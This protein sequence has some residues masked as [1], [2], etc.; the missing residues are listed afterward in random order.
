VFFI[1]CNQTKKQK[2]ASS[3]TVSK[4]TIIDTLP[5]NLQSID[6]ENEEQNICFDTLKIV[7]G[8]RNL[9]YY[10]FGIH[11]NIEEFLGSLPKEIVATKQT[12]MNGRETYLIQIKNNYIEV[13][14]GEDY[15]GKNNPTVNIV[16]AEIKD[17]T[18]EIVNSIKIGMTK[19][20]F[21]EILNLTNINDLN[22]INVV[23]LIS[24]LAGIWQYYIFN[25]NNI[26]TK[27]EIKSDYV[28]E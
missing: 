22:E 8:N 15:S 14:V 10:P 11:N 2:T 6:L 7:S 24:V 16:N 20:T 4:D 18:I 25:E 1:G 23:E 3:S 13:L 9:L 12:K 26:L 21:I 28:F 19:Q 27:I 5:Q 17:N